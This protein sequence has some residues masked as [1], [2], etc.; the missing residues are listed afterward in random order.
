MSVARGHLLSNHLSLAW[1]KI[2]TLLLIWPLLSTQDTLSNYHWPD[3]CDWFIQGHTPLDTTYKHI[4]RVCLVSDNLI[5]FNSFVSHS[6][7]V[8]VPYHLVSRW[9][10]WKGPTGLVFKTGTQ[11]QLLWFQGLWRTSHCFIKLKPA[12]NWEIIWEYAFENGPHVWV[13]FWK[14][15]EEKIFPIVKFH[16]NLDIFPGG[17]VF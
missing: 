1:S 2:N 9:E 13:S 10:N 4:L 3:L 7:I 8:S 5:L 16:L 14:R 12:N 11:A 6:N 15:M 17:S